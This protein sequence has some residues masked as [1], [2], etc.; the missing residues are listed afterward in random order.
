MTP[1]EVTAI[2]FT[3]DSAQATAA[4]PD[5]G[6][7]AT[8]D[9]ANISVINITFDVATGEKRAVVLERESNGQYRA[10]VVVEP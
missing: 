8:N 9:R 4:L 7:V 2:I 3:K 1:R 5:T 6:V 10:Q